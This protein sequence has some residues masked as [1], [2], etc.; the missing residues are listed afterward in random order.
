LPQ[1]LF[2]LRMFQDQVFKKIPV[3]AIDVPHGLRLPS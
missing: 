1:P 2:A 3:A